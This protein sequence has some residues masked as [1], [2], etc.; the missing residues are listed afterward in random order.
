METGRTP[1]KV[2]NVEEEEKPMKVD[3]WFLLSVPGPQEHQAQPWWLLEAITGGT[4]DLWRLSDELAQLCCG[5]V[6][7]RCIT[8]E[9]DGGR[10]SKPCKLRFSVGLFVAH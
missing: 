1:G 2:W 5:T 7:D 3:D 6:P 8:V 4:L 10:K 9:M